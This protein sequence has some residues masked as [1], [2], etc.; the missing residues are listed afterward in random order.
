[1]RNDFPLEM[2]SRYFLPNCKPDCIF[3]GHPKTVSNISLVT[4][5]E[6][7]AFI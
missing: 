7:I 5:V 3:Q 1:M 4:I 2:I 6:E